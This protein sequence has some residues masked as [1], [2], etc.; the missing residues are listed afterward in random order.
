MKVNKPRPSGLLAQAHSIVGILKGFHLL[1]LGPRGLAV[2]T[3]W[4]P[5]RPD[6][7]LLQP[8]GRQV[9]APL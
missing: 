7:V 4:G 6:K 3:G 9:T 5:G 8:Q 1:E 2:E